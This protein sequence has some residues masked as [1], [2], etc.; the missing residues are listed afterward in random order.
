MAKQFGI[1]F[2]CL[3]AGELIAMIPGVSIPGSIIG[4]LVL[5][6]L[7]ERKVVKPDSIAPLCRFLIKN[8]AF[9]FVPPGVALMLYFDIIAAE[10]IPITVATVVSIFLVIV[11]TGR[12]HQ[13]MH[14]RV[15][16]NSK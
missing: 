4:M 3:L 10:W 16:R 13:F 5:T 11:V 9:F 15:K 6:V 8:M 2:A 1:I 7:L 12:L 14:R